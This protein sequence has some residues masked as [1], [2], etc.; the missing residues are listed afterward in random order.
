MVSGIARGR[1][2][3][4]AATTTVESRKMA[5]I[6]QIIGWQRDAALVYL[7]LFWYMTS[8][9][10]QL[11]PAKSSYPLTSTTWPYRGLKFIA[12]W[13]Q[14][15]IKVDSCQVKLLKSSWVVRKPVNSKLGLKVNQIVTVSSIE[16][17]SMCSFCLCIGFVI[18]KLRIEG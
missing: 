16:F 3:T 14:C 1:A 10:D 17:F 2:R 9:Y 18:I 5:A 4:T 13:G 6:L 8:C 12:R 15:F 11:T 7:V